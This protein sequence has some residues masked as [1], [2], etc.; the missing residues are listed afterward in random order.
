MVQ[1]SATSKRSGQQCQRA[2]APGATVC[3]SHG[4][5]A[6]QVRAAAQRRLQAEA[7]RQDLDRLG[8]ALPDTDPGQALQAM[9]DEAAGNVTI[10]RELVAGLDRP[11]ARLYHANGEA[12]GRAEPHVLVAMYDAERDR[13]HRLSK[14]A[15]ALGLEERRTRVE[16]GQARQLAAAV[17]AALNVLPDGAREEFRAALAQQLRSLPR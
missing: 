5:K 17:N 15:L 2:A 14:D 7:A 12:T 16:E 8:V 9:I 11:Y 13:L 10:L 1:C 3:A 6:P 4:A